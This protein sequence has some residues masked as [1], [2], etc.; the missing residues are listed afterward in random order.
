MK[1]NQCPLCKKFFEGNS[2][3]ISGNKGCCKKCYDEHRRNGFIKFNADA[4]RYSRYNLTLAFI[5]ILASVAVISGI[6]L[7]FCGD[8]GY[9]P[10]LVIAGSFIIGLTTFFSFKVDKK[11]NA[12][13]KK[14]FPDMEF[15]Y[16]L[17]EEWQ[18]IT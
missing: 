9:W 1:D 15:D 7:A 4:Q 2:Y 8:V 10:V 6:I 16:E 12:I 11:L 18:K 5:G 17:P 14:Q 13:L 3:E